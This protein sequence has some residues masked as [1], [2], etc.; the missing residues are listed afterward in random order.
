[1]SIWNSIPDRAIDNV[2]GSVITTDSRDSLIFEGYAWCSRRVITIASGISNIVIDTTA[3]AGTNNVIALLPPIFT[4]V[5][6]ENIIITCY[7]GTTY[8]Q[9]TSQIIM[10]RNQLYSSKVPYVK[11]I[12][13]P[14]IVSPGEETIQFLL[15]SSAQGAFTTTGISTIGNIIVA[16]NSINT[17]LEINNLSTASAVI[18]YVLTWAEIPIG[19]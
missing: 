10:N 9:G 15:P 3:S 14:T 1:M 5:G 19:K 11:I 4:G 6:D 8:T 2:V 18:E 13:N 16:D 12:Y 17:R 7:S